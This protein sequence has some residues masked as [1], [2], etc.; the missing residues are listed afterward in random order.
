MLNSTNGQSSLKQSSV[1]TN[2]FPKHVSIQNYMRVGPL[3]QTGV[4][5]VH[6]VEVSCTILMPIY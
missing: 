5:S 1:L 6:L 3:G 4:I 2:M